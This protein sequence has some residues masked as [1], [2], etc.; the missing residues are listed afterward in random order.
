MFRRIL[1]GAAAALL[2]VAPALAQQAPWPG[3]RQVRILVTYPPGGTSDFVARLLAQKLGEQTGGNFTVDNRSGG[4]GIIGWTNV[5]RSANDGTTLLLTDNSL[6]T[7]PPLYPNLGFDVRTDFTPISLMVDYPTVFV[8]PGN[9]PIRSLRDYV[10]AARG[11]AAD[12]NFYGSMGSGSSP[13][14]YTE[15]L[16]DIAG[17]RLTHVP[18]RGMGPAFLDLL[19]GRVGLLIAAPPTVLGA[20][21]DGRARAIAIGTT[22]G[23]IPALP[24]VPTAKELGFE[25][26][27]S[28]W[29]GLLGPRGMD[30][31]LVAQ[32]RGEVDKVLANP[33]VRARFVQQ[34]ATPVGGDGAALAAVMESDLARWSEVVRAKG[35]TVQ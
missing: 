6:A 28:F 19:A 22:G 29:Y 13:H 31:A 5:V 32:I 15:Y 1:L 34:G 16:Q 21:R 17:I 18:Y 10:D 24:D 9:S 27:Y 11:Q 2:A 30:P 7:A 3:N 25:F 12:A 14:L 23:R 8:V 20:V 33:E 4:G 26:T 35:I